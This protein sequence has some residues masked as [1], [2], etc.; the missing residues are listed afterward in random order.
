[1]EA[2]WKRQTAAEV[3]Q[4]RAIHRSTS[5]IERQATVD[6]SRRSRL[7][8]RRSPVRAGHRP[9][10]ARGRSSGWKSVRATPANASCSTTTSGGI[11]IHVAARVNA[12]AGAGEV[13]VEGTV[14]DL[15]V[16]AEIASVRKVRL[17]SRA[18]RDAGRCSWLSPLRA[19]AAEC[20]HAVGEPR[21]SSKALPHREAEG[22]TALEAPPSAR[23]VP[24]GVLPPGCCG[25]T[26]DI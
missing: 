10:S 18:S 21:T 24:N 19:V 8:S 17:R 5:G 9:W 22:C 20:A 12:L 14:K 6:R 2:T 7:T 4:P 1:M 11:A 3:Q 16:G 13:L 25:G 15:V 26:P 23:S